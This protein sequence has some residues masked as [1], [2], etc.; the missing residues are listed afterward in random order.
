M[1][2]IIEEAGGV[3]TDWTGART[4][5]GGDVIATN[6]ALAAAVRELL[7]RDVALAE[8]GQLTNGT[9]PEAGP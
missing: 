3:L 6:G 8:H 9:A 2:P 1:L 7:V 4:A 5:F